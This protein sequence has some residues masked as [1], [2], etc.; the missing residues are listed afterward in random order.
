[1][2][3]RKLDHETWRDFQV[4]A[5]IVEYLTPG[6]EKIIIIIIIINYFYNAH[7]TLQGMS[8]CAVRKKEVR[9]RHCTGS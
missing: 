5:S 9:R 8:L 7:N 3:P 6:G 1:M 2:N 4:H